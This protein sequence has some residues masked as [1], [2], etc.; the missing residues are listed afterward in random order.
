MIT[1]ARYRMGYG[2]L[3]LDVVK[4]ASPV[5]RRG[6]ASNRSFLFGNI[7]CHDPFIPIILKSLRFSQIVNLNPTKTSLHFHLLCY[8]EFTYS[9]N[10]I[11]LFLF[12]RTVILF[13]SLFHNKPAWK[14]CSFRMRGCI[15]NEYVVH[16]A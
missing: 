15:C 13:T 16:G 2:R 9:F 14:W 12:H 1:A 3:E 10:I 4:V 5:L 8:T 11:L 6:K 7:F